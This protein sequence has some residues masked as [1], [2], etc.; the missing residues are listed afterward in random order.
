MKKNM[1][2]IFIALLLAGGLFTSCDMDLQPRDTL[3]DQTA[4]QNINDCLKFR[5]GL[6]TSMRGLT[7]GS[8]INNQEIQMDIFQGVIGNG[9]QVG[10]FA[11]GN[12]LSSD[13]DIESKW[14]SL[15]SVINSAN[16]I[17]EKME[18]MSADYTD[19]QLIELKRY[20]GEARFVRAYCYYWLADHFCQTY[21]SD[22]GETS[23]LGLPLVTK[24]HPT[25]DRGSY[26]SRST[27]NETYSLIETDLNYALTALQEYEATGNAPAANS[28]YLSSYAVMALQ[29]RIALLKGEYSTALSKAEEVITSGTYSLTTIQDYAKLWSNDEGTEVIFRPFMSASE[30]GSSTGGSYFLSDNEES[31][32]YIPTE[33]MLSLYDEENDIR[34]STFFIVYDGLQS[35]GLTVSA[36]VFNKYPGNESLKTGTQRNFVNMMKPFRLSEL[37]LIAA[38]SAAAIGDASNIT[39]A[40]SYLNTLRSNRINNYKNVTLSGSNLTQQIRTERLKELI[41][42]GFRLSDLR[43]WNLGF[44]RNG[45]YPRN[46]EVEN[47]FVTSGKNISYQAG[48]YRFVWPIPATEMQSNPQLAG[49][50]NP[51]Y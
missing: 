7:A 31:A 40:N 51:G 50:Q 36:Y 21:S 43:R 33:D 2:K 47:I 26:P 16:Y 18:T 8:W 42:E 20:E 35:N 15:Y 11:N 45:N 24:Y 29:A 9:N 10:T 25:S 30:L 6:Y 14:S 41:G 44:T 4:I 19:A 49:Q 28:H 1:K 13:Q 22:K 46:P 12:I 32:W 38:E 34:F 23:A 27:L 17:I 5:N 3:D 37:Y 39:K 48:D